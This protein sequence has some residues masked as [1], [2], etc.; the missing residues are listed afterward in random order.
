[1]TPAPQSYASEPAVPYR[2][3]PASPYGD[4][5]AEDPYGDGTS[6]LPYGPTPEDYLHTVEPANG[7]S[8]RSGTS[9]I[10]T[11]PD[12]W[13]SGASTRATSR[14][15]KRNDLVT[16]MPS[17]TEVTIYTLLG[18][19]IASTVFVVGGRPYWHVAPVV[20][21]ALVIILLSAL[22][23]RRAATRAERPEN[24]TSEVDVGN[25]P[26]PSANSRRGRRRR[27]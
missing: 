22:I 20:W 14:Y 4:T 8:G 24:P 12:G 10:V 13:P 7:H 27:R 21:S 26:T 2:H 18:A 9:S 19:A 11:P 1:M 3:T 15:R 5:P 17:V 16:G 23:S 6:G 25:T